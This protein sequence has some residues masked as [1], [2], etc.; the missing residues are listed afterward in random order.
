MGAL[1]VHQKHQGYIE[2]SAQTRLPVGDAWGELPNGTYTTSLKKSLEYLM[3]SHFSGFLETSTE[4][5]RSPKANK[6]KD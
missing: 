2:S 1:R 6:L 5:T 4:E 3:G